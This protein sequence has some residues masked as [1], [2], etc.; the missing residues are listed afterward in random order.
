MNEFRDQDSVSGPVSSSHLKGKAT[1]SELSSIVPGPIQAT[2]PT[3]GGAPSSCPY[4][5][6]SQ[7]QGHLFDTASAQFPSS[8]EGLPNSRMTSKRADHHG[9]T[10]NRESWNWR[11]PRESRTSTQQA[12]RRYQKPGESGS[13]FNT[14]ASE[15]RNMSNSGYKSSSNLRYLQ[16]AAPAT[17]EASNPSQQ[18]R[19]L[20]IKSVY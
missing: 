7:S 18:I 11:K 17:K 16:Q 15:D 8:N 6:D 19:S 13:Y 1:A 9:L 20:K 14:R 4:K 10:F 2:S 3:I 5:H 12:G